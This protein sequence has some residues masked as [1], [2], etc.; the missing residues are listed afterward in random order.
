MVFGGTKIQGASNITRT[1]AQR[2][3]A[4]QVA[5]NITG[6]VSAERAQETLE[7]VAG[8]LL[9]GKQLAIHHRTSSK[10]PRFIRQSQVSH[11]RATHTVAV[12]RNLF[13]KAGGQIADPAKQSALQQEVE[14]YLNTPNLAIEGDRL[15][16]LVKQ[17]QEAIAAG[18]PPQLDGQAPMGQPNLHQQNS[19][20]LQVA[21]PE[22][23]QQAIVPAK[24]QG[25]DMPGEP[26]PQP[27]SDKLADELQGMKAAAAKGRPVSQKLPTQ[28]DILAPNLPDPKLPDPSQLS[29][30]TDALARKIEDGARPIEAN[31]SLLDESGQTN[32]DIKQSEKFNEVE[33]AQT[34]EVS[35]DRNGNE[36]QPDAS[37]LEELP[38]SQRDSS[39]MI[40]SQIQPENL[41]ESQGPAWQESF[42]ANNDDENLYFNPQRPLSSSSFFEGLMEGADGQQYMAEEDQQYFNGQ[43]TS[44]IPHR[45]EAEEISQG[46]IGEEDPFLPNPPGPI[47]P[48]LVPGPIN[49][50]L[51]EDDD[52][53]FDVDKQISQRAAESRQVVAEV[54]AKQ[55]AEKNIQ[56][57]NEFVGQ[58]DNYTE[59]LVDWEL[60]FDQMST[61]Q[62][63]GLKDRNL[64]GTAKELQSKLDT[65]ERLINEFD[66]RL[67]DQRDLRKLRDD[68]G[69]LASSLDNNFGALLDERDELTSQVDNFLDRLEADPKAD[70]VIQESLALTDSIASSLGELLA[71]RD[72]LL[73]AAPDEALV[74]QRQL[75]Y[76]HN[77]LSESETILNKAKPR[78]QDLAKEAVV[79][80]S[81]F[82]Q[83]FSNARSGETQAIYA[84]VQIRNELKAKQSEIA[85]LETQLGRAESDLKDHE[86]ELRKVFGEIPTM[87]A[88]VKDRQSALQDV[89]QGMQQ[90]AR[91]IEQALGKKLQVQ[92][93]G[94][95]Q[96]T[97]PDDPEVQA[98]LRN[99]T[100]FQATAQPETDLRNYESQ[101]NNLL[102]LTDSELPLS[103]AQRIGLQA[104]L[105]PDGL[106]ATKLQDLVDTLVLRL[107]NER[108]QAFA[109]ILRDYNKRASAA[110]GVANE[111]SRKKQLLAERVDARARQIM[112]LQG[113]IRSLN[114]MLASRENLP[115]AAVASTLGDEDRLAAL[116]QE[117]QRL[118]DG[119][120][121]PDTDEMSES[122]AEEA[123][124]QAMGLQ[125]LEV[126]LAKV[127]SES[128]QAINEVKQA[129]EDQTKARGEAERAA[130]ARIEDANLAIGKIE[131]VMKRVHQQLSA[132]NQ[133]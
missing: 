8:K 44:Y 54:M 19:E 46:F 11:E 77:L 103:A 110:Q 7:A 71:R 98:S 61:E 133:R 10:T 112:T 106:I 41:D 88:A 63:A 48:G 90:T 84:L 86:Q 68:V 49:P 21:Q 105:K 125:G 60:M 120:D 93:T 132:A 87:Q 83:L 15:N 101:L 6:S 82:D 95:V 92:R 37:P 69:K 89:R 58:V 99:L 22:P 9:K 65:L 42:E 116:E 121:P 20:A 128:E 13:A 76:Q 66:G 80:R 5:D 130:Q 126:E 113:Q 16:K 27:A 1:D 85:A 78:S 72:H 47:G 29:G 67:E 109:D 52:G 12:V 18:K 2:L 62:G 64:K 107:N 28:A 102:S 40:D 32:R 3:S 45:S 23:E 129:Q 26:A 81:R 17:L 53:E 96:T 31:Q 97:T 55:A 33:F 111:A 51:S 34:S 131:A 74:A 59:S 115:D 4:T 57:W 30:G 73:S 122:A 39:E 75:E 124:W 43:R 36:L 118:L 38:G 123:Q 108:E 94:T 100:L 91:D 50:A 119:V 24:P 35:V 114:R 79:L 70:Q 14:S 56:A 127:T 117:R 25:P 104:A